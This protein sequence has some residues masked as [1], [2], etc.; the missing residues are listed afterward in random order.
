MNKRGWIRIVEAF[1][2]VLLI[3]GVLL[4]V[5]GKGYIGKKDISE[6]V[7]QVQLAVLREIELNSTLRTSILEVDESELPWENF[8]AEGLSDVKQK[9]EDRIP[10]Y[11]ECEAKICELDRVCPMGSTLVEKD[12]YAQSVAITAE[13]E[14]YSPRQ[15]KLFCWT[16]G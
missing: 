11:L 7:Y 3:A 8:S 10:E 1:I 4:F 13:G 2:A 5:I 12:V 16:A 15:L 14:K 9:I 6:Q